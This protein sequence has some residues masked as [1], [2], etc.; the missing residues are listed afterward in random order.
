MLWLA[1][2]SLA[3][4]A[5]SALVALG[6]DSCSPAFLPLAAR[7]SAVLLNVKTRA[8]RRQHG[9]RSGSPGSRRRRWGSS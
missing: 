6:R 4:A 5:L 8:V 1:R 2:T 9:A 7:F 3:R